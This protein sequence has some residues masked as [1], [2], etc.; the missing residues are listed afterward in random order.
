MTLGEQLFRWRLA[1]IVG[2]F[3]LAA[4]YAALDMG[5]H[6]GLRSLAT[7]V[8]LERAFLLT[9]P[10]CLLAFALRLSGEARL[11]A[12]VYGQEASLRVVTGGPF[13][14]S[15]HPLYLGTWLFFAAASAP[16]LP[17]L[18]LAVLA[19]GFAT[20]LVAIARYEERALALVHGEAWARYARAV[21]RVLGPASGAVDDDGIAPSARA[22]G[23]ALAGNLFFL[24]LGVYR[25]AAGLGEPPKALAL[26]NL[27]CLGLWLLVVAA[28]RLRH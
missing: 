12:V 27:A 24:S 5:L 25:I 15:R 28:R 18:V 23:A 13:R 14:F 17:P 22:W 2:A 4:G 10:V 19:A 8:G 6:L 1:V 7:L 21:P 20:A 3:G 11:G 26:L 16:Y 9:G